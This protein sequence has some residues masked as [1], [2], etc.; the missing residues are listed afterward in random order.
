MS[1]FVHWKLQ[2]G[3]VPA[4]RCMALQCLTQCPTHWHTDA[5]CGLQLSI[6][7]INYLVSYPARLISA[8]NRTRSHS[9]RQMFLAT[10]PPPKKLSA[11][12]ITRLT[13]W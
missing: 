4:C 1:E 2:T 10:F 5:V 13:W 8:S 6:I 11:A 3:W 9:Q 7:I 12:A